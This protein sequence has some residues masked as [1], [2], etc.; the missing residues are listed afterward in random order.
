MDLDKIVESPWRAQ[1]YWVSFRP[2]SKTPKDCPSITWDPVSAAPPIG[3]D[4]QD[5]TWPDRWR[6]YVKSAIASSVELAWST[7]PTSQRS[8]SGFPGSRYVD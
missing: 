4:Q 7:E 5:M 1:G 8:S 6:H 2:G 3:F